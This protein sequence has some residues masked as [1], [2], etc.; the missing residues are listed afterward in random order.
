MFIKSFDLGNSV[1]ILR[2]PSLKM[3]IIDSYRFL[4]MPLRRFNKRFVDIEPELS[5]GH[6]PFRTIDPAWYEYEGSIPSVEWFGCSDEG[7]VEEVEQFIRDYGDKVWNWK[8]NLHEYLKVP[9][10][11]FSELPC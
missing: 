11:R 4:S 2:I 5:K 9:E 8:E 1:L 7:Q 3:Q 10:S 6:F